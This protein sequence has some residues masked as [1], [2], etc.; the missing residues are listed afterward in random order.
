MD[1]DDVEQIS[2]TTAYQGYFRVN[3]YKL[4]HRLFAGG[5]SD[6]IQREVFERGHAAAAILYDP[7]ADAVVLIEQFRAGAYAAGG[8]PW[9]TEIVA[10][11][12]EPGESPEAVVRRESVEEAGCAVL[13]LVPICLYFVSP[14]ATSETVALY[15]ARV[16]SRGVGGIHGLA[17]EHEDI[18]VEVVPL[19]RALAEFAAG[20]INNAPTIIALQYLALNRESLRGRW[21]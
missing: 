17:H 5:W 3:A 9:L 19:D 18:R 15:C 16:D 12:V 14:G 21:R 1:R 2:R 4:R 6:T 13:D 11:I 10:G 8:P 20:R 7:L